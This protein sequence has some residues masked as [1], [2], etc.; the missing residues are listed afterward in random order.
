MLATNHDIRIVASASGNSS[1]MHC[2]S[3]G[4]ETHANGCTRWK[5]RFCNGSVRMGYKR[6]VWSLKH[7]VAIIHCSVQKPCL[8]IMDDQETYTGLNAK[9]LENGF[10]IIPLLSYCPNK[11]Q[12][13]AV[14]MPFKAQL[15]TSQQNLVTVHG[16]RVVTCNVS[17]STKSVCDHHLR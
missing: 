15:R 8:L 7:L 11:L 17:G 12:P 9:L 2:F 1:A 16:R 13:V 6:N 3:Q 5:S 14:F 10:R 4:E